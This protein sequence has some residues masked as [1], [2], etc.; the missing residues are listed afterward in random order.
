[1]PEHVRDMIKGAGD[2]RIDILVGC[3]TIIAPP[4]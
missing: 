3:D 4:L 2:A 1:V